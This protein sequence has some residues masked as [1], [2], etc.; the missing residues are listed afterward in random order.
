MHATWNSISSF[1]STEPPEWI[2]EE[3]EEPGGREDGAGDIY[4]D[5]SGAVGDVMSL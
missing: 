1:L 2:F 3:E 5:E 4:A